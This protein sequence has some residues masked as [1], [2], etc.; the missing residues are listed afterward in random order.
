M[1]NTSYRYYSHAST[2]SKK[3]DQEKLPPDANL[4]FLM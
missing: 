1:K 3:K 4:F 2:S